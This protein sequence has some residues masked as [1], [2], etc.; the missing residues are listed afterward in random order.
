MGSHFGTQTVRIFRNADTDDETVEEVEAHIQ[1]EKGFFDVDTSIFEGDLVEVE[2]PR[3]PEGVERR[4][5]TKVKV[6]NMGP[7][8]MRHISVT[9]G[10]AVPPRVAPVRRLTFENLHPEVQSAAGDLFADGQYEAAVSEAFKSIEVRVRTV[11]GLDRSGAPLMAEAFKPDAPTIDVAVHE[12]QSG[13]DEREG[14]LHIFRG[15]MI[16]IRNP[17]AHELFET[18]DPQQALEYL[19]MASLLHRRIDSAGGAQR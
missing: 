3:R 6:N 4:L 17:K 15:S 7:S 13:K 12:G 8:D 18:G 1:G 2:D 9:W 10:R 5:A 11:T 16:G 14:F 19:G